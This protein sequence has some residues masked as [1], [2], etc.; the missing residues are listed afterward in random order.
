MKPLKLV[1]LVLLTSLTTNPKGFTFLSG[2]VFIFVFTSS[3]VFNPSNSKAIDSLKNYYKCLNF[4]NFDGLTCEIFFNTFNS[5]KTTMQYVI[6]ITPLM[7]IYPL[8]KFFNLK[9]SRVVKSPN[10]L[11]FTLAFLLWLNFFFDPY[12][13]EFELFFA[14]GLIQIGFF[15]MG[16]SVGFVLSLVYMST[17]FMKAFNFTNYTE[18][19]Y[20]ESTSTNMF[21]YISYGTVS[22]VFILTFTKL[23]RL[24]QKQL[25]N[26][27][28]S[29]GSD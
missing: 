5:F 8:S 20:H 25:Q 9:H 24:K 21:N 22:L 23:K 2:L 18:M 13:S 6:T 15:S 19:S 28:Q 29:S 16:F 4:I 26:K 27:K 14:I 1:Y 17:A 10:I 12:N 7:A 3:T 11:K